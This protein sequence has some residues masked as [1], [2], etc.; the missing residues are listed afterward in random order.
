MTG[1]AFVFFQPPFDDGLSGDA[2]VISSGHPKRIESLH[3]LHS[4]QYILQRVVERVTKMQCTSDV[5]WR[6]DNRVRLTRR[7]WRG[8]KVTAILP[9]L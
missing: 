4:N 7:I 8:V 3:P 1:L 6:D 9:P 5:G 2:S